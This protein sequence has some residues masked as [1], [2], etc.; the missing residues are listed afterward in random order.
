MFMVCG[1]SEVIFSIRNRKIIYDWDWYIVFGILI[2]V[3]GIYVLKIT[4]YTLG[5]WTGFVSL[6]RS[7][8]LLGLVVELRKYGGVEWRNVIL[9][10]AC[11]VIFSLMLISG[12]SVMLMTGLVLI[13]IGIEIGR[14]H[15]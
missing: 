13:V 11:G 1:I 15:V 14:A 8:I 2:F 7:G 3:M 9:C 10:S 6:F 5:L 4:N 12:V